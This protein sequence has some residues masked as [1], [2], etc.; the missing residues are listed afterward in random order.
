MEQVGDWG[1]RWRQ[2]SGHL[3]SGRLG[4]LPQ[5]AAW[6]MRLR[7]A[8]Q[9]SGAVGAPDLSC[10][11]A[12]IWPPEPQPQREPGAG[13]GGGSAAAVTAAKEAP[14]PLA[15]WASLA[16]APADTCLPRPRPIRGAW[17]G[18]ACG[19]GAGARAGSP[20][21]GGRALA[22]AP[23]PRVP[24]PRAP[25]ALLRRA[26]GTRKRGGAQREAGLGTLPVVPCSAF[27]CGAVRCWGTDSAIPRGD[28][29][30]FP[31]LK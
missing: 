1:H 11:A 9:G 7:A 31:A 13:A 12:G 26:G 15:A 28:L 6:I 25:Q 21:G 20:A 4:N 14:A 30:S 3:F 17:G 29:R 22:P 23:G 8:R 16:A 18:G 10:S 5:R 24:A 19:G 27:L 2:G